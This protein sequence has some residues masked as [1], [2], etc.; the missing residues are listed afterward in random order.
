[1]ALAWQNARKQESL[2]GAQ[3]QKPAHGTGSAFEPN[4]EPRMIC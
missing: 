4:V 2:D 1:M 3:G